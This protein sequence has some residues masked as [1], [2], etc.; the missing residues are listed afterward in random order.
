MMDTVLTDM[1]ERGVEETFSLK[2]EKKTTSNR[3]AGLRFHLLNAY[4][5]ALNPFHIHSRGQKTKDQQE[6]RLT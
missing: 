1:V 6:L 3:V 2:Y 5:A 4:K